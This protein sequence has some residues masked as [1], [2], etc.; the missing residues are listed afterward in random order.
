[1]NPVEILRVVVASPGDVQAERDTLSIVVDELNRTIASASGV[2]LEVTRWEKDA[3][4]GFNVEGPQG[5][6]DP[7]LRIED[8]EVFIGIFWNRFGTP[9]R[10][11]QSGTE[12][13]FTCAYEAWKE[14]SS[15]HIMFYFNQEPFIPASAEEVDQMARVIEFQRT[16]PSEGLWWPY[17]G[18]LQFERVVREHLTRFILDRFV[19]DEEDDND[20]YDDGEPLIFEEDMTL[21][22]RT[23]A[24][25]PC[26]LEEN[27]QIKITVSSEAPVDIIIMDYDDYR[28]WEEKGSLDTLYEHYE[29]R[30]HFHGFYK[31]R[32]DGEY[33]VVVC[34]KSRDEIETHVSISNH[35]A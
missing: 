15:P 22:G 27:D 24:K 17:S 6:I 12:H 35:K 26:D 16:F 32:G 31:A 21:E 25:I 8:C 11:A 7:V 9:V 13:E 34:N 10:G 14:N 33:L 1:M 29:D 19:E 4:P 18:P 30:K 20:D 5:L 28:A 23:H 3:Y 2:R